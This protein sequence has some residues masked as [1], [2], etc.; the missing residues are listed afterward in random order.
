MLGMPVICR[1]ESIG[2]VS[3]VELTEDL[4]ALKGIYLY[5]GVSGTRFIEGRELDLV[6][7]VAVLARS[8]G[9]KASRSPQSLLRRAIGPDGQR[10]GAVTDA[11]VDEESLRVAALEVSRGWLEDLTRGRSCV[12]AYSVCPDGQVLINQ[13]GGGEMK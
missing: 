8:E 5:R 12:D 9:H 11:F 13:S 1:G 4:R 6:G 3:Q 2:R 7:E 10:L